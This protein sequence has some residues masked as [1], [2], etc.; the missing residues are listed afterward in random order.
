MMANKILELLKKVERKNI[1]IT[2]GAARN[3]MIDR[4][5]ARGNSRVDRSGRSPL[6]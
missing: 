1:I 6:F 5:S 3:H 4:L 2:G